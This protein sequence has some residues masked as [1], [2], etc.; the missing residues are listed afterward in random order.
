ED[1]ATPLLIIEG[2]KKAIAACLAG[3]VAVAIGG[4]DSWRAKGKVIPR[5]AGIEMKDRR[6]FVVHDSDLARKPHVRKA[7]EELTSYL[8]TCK[9]ADVR[10]TTLSDSPDGDKQ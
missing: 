6:V 9:E 3:Q 7:R 5:L 2:E 1:V 4:V 10:W 8:Q